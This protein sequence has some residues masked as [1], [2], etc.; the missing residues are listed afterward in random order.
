MISGLRT[1]YTNT[2]SNG[3]TATSCRVVG[4]DQQAVDVEDPGLVL[5]GTKCD[6]GKVI[7]L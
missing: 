7:C 3:R 2:F 1:I 5:T 6:T 4:S